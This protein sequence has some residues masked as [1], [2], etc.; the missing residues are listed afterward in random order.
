MK[1]CI[2]CGKEFP[3]VGDI[4]PECL[5]TIQQSAPSSLTLSP[6]QSSFAD[7]QYE[8]PPTCIE[9]CT[10]QDKVTSSLWSWSATVES[11]GKVLC[12]LIIFGGILAAFNSSMIE[13]GINSYTGETKTEFSGRVFGTVAVTYIIY[14]VAEYCVYRTVA[15]LI[16]ALARITQSSRTTARLQ[17]YEI[18]HR[19][20][21]YDKGL[22]QSAK[23]EGR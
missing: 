3:G 12:I 16:A 10:N 22:T 7:C 1:Y 18:R 4:C 8:K 6:P 14:A 13:T 11:I 20:T 2:Q 21:Q 23:D 19:I 15:L 9:E 17:E 5:K